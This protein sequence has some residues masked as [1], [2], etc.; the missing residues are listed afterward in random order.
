MDQVDTDETGFDR[1]LGFTL[2]SR[3]VR[4]R[5]VRLGPAVDQILAAHDY[6]PAV[7]NLLAE[8]LVL[9]TLMG[10]LLK[11]EGQLTMQA[12][13]EEGAVTLLVCDYRE[14]ALRGYAEVDRGRIVALGANPPLPALFGANAYLAITF[15]LPLDG[16]RYQGIVPLDGDTLSGACEHYFRQSE[17][18]PT[19]IRVAARSDGEHAV[20]GG[21]LVQHLPD[22]EE[23]RERLHVRYDDPDWEHVAIM[24]GSVRHAEL[25]DPQTMLETILWRLFHE[26][27][28]IRTEKLTAVSRGCR[29]SAAHF[30]DVL[31]RFAEAERAEMREDDG[32]VHVDCAFCSKIFKVAV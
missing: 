6:P 4:G 7:K 1:V 13:S 26:E 15:D 24:G 17:Q 14:G 18:L 31:G 10:S 23:G 8:A 27:D 19:L 5:S 9:C 25:V 21:I 29:C 12:Q 16:G 3:E 32:L 11:N 30:A 20:A 28:E 2:P 22:G